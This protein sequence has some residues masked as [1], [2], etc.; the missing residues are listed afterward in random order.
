MPWHHH[1]QVLT[2]DHLQYTA[3]E[4]LSRLLTVFRAQRA[5]PGGTN[6]KRLLSDLDVF[7]LGALSK[8]CKCLYTI[9]LWLGPT[10]HSQ[11]PLGRPIPT[12]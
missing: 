8:L 11:S 12:S 4:Q 1:I 3:F 6:P 5:L 10:K 7:W 9:W 2:D